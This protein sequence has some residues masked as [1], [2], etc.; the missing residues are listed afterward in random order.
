MKRS[1]KLK[2]QCEWLAGFRDAL[3]IC[4]DLSHTIIPDRLTDICLSL[5]QAVYEAD[6]NES[7]T[8]D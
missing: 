1:E 2:L 3:I 6:K 8:A 5:S 7:Q 4:E